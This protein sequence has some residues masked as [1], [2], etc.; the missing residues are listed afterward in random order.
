MHKL[1][2]LQGEAPITFKVCCMC[3]ISSMNNRVLNGSG[4]LM[5]GAPHVWKDIIL[6]FLGKYLTQLDQSPN[7]CA[8]ILPKLNHRI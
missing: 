4:S 3:C 7:V 1:N 2:K 8:D 5:Q 6:I